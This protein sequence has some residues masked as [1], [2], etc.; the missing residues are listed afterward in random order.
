[1]GRTARELKLSE[2]AAGINFRYDIGSDSPNQVIEIRQHNLRG[3]IK[4]V[5]LITQ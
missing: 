5:R 2:L 3:G 1:V 4:E